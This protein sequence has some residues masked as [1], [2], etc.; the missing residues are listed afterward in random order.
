[1]A[2]SP[3][4]NAAHGEAGH[5]EHAHGGTGL[6]VKVFLALCG[7]TACS[8]FT[9]SD[10]WPFHAT[11]AVGWVFMMAVSCTKALLVMTFFMHLLWEANWK[12][13]LTIPASLMS[14]FLVIALV[15]DVGQ[16]VRY[17]TEER[18]LNSSE[19][20]TTPHGHGEE[21]EGQ[22]EDKKHG[23]QDHAGHDH[24]KDQ[25]DEKGA[26]EGS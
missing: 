14:V 8:F 11:P 16:R 21:G 26:A 18:W 6:Y 10:Y 24:A 13:V 1:M 12:Y 17:Y 2:H 22:H 19:E 4:Q 23:D 15:P 7:L 25:A 20:Q 3:Q 9:V 5:G